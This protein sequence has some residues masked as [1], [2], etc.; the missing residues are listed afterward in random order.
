LSVRNPLTLSLS[1]APPPPPPTQFD[2]SEWATPTDVCEC[3]PEPGGLRICCY[4]LCCAPCAIAEVAESVGLE[5]AGAWGAGAGAAQC[6]G[7]CVGGGVNVLS[8]AGVGIFSHGPTAIIAT[9]SASLVQAACL[10]A[11]CSLVGKLRHEQMGRHGIE[12]GTDISCLAPLCCFSCILA[13]QLNHERAL[14]RL[15][16]AAEKG[17]PKEGGDGGGFTGGTGGGDGEGGGRGRVGDA[18]FRAAAWF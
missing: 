10:L 14:K 13:Q 16:G 5:H 4:A 12:G 18:L 7:Y 8:R 6:G 15:G 1:A 17:A 9:A 3:G 2:G 11:F